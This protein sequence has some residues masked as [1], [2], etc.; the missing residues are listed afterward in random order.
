MPLFL[1]R[2]PER[3]GLPTKWIGHDWNA[4]VHLDQPSPMERRDET[5]TISKL[6]QNI[7]WNST[8][9]HA[10]HTYLRISRGGFE[11]LLFPLGQ[12]LA[13]EARHL[14]NDAANPQ[15][16]HARIRQVAQR[17][18]QCRDLRRLRDARVEFCKPAEDM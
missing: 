11:I 10:R 4:L 3:Q 6:R 12:A 18:D 9:P 16:N 14:L 13:H 2:A 8:L 15:Q 1:G 5:L 17:L 7:C